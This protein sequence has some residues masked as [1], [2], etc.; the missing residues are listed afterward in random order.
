M[1][2]DDGNAEHNHQ[3]TYSSMTDSSDGS[4]SISH[5][6]SSSSQS[7]DEAKNFEMKTICVDSSS[8][9]TVKATYK[10]DTVRFKFEPSAGCFELYEE[11]ARRFKL[12]TGT[13][14]LKY[15]DDEEE[16]VM[17]VSDSDL[18]ECLEVME[19]V[20]TH[21]VKF[22]VRDVP[23]AIGSSGGSNCFLGGS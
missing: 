6:S 14:Q 19:F 23:C 17:L 10:D 13:F 2:A 9:I 20:G 18:Q 15:L 22:Q 4:G 8:K 5:G 11:I 3:P 21:N 12:Q 16:W 1:E 7:F